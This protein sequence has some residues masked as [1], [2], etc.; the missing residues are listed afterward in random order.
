M[1]V[2]LLDNSINKYFRTLGYLLKSSMKQYL[3]NSASCIETY[4]VE[5]FK[6]SNLS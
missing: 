3:F 6:K 4:S 5:F 1:T 2:P